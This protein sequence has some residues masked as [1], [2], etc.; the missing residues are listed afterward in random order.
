MHILCPPPSR[1]TAQI[2]VFVRQWQR[3]NRE[4]FKQVVIIYPTLLHTSNY[5][6]HKQRRREKVEAWWGEEEAQKQS[7]DVSGGG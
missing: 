4:K 5:R 6:E 7:G 2:K 3:A 1:S